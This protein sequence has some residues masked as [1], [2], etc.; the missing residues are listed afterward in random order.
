MLRFV[1]LLIGALF[2]LLVAALVSITPTDRVDAGQELVRTCDGDGDLAFSE[3]SN[4]DNHPELWEN[5]ANVK[6]TFGPVMVGGT[7]TLKI[8][9][10]TPDG[11]VSIQ[12]V[13]APGGQFSGSAP[14]T[15]AGISTRVDFLGRMVYDEKNPQ[16]PRKEKADWYVG[17]DGALPDSNSDGIHQPIVF[18]EL[19]FFDYEPEDEDSDGVSS[20]TD[21][22]STANMEGT[23]IQQPGPLQYN[24]TKKDETL[25]DVL[26]ANPGE[27]AIDSQRVAEGDVHFYQGHSI[28][29]TF[30]LELGAG[31]MFTFHLPA[32]LG[33]NDVAVPIR[34]DINWFIELNDAATQ[35]KSMSMIVDIAGPSFDFLNGDAETGVWRWETVQ[36]P[37]TG[38]LDL[39][40]G[41][42][43]IALQG[44]FIAENLKV[45][46]AGEE[47]IPL[48]LS[49][50]MTGTIAPFTTAAT[51]VDNCPD[52]ANADQL[53]TDADGIGDVCDFDFSDFDCDGDTDTTDALKQVSARAGLTVV[54]ELGC[55]LPGASAQFAGFSVTWGN[56][57]CDEEWNSM[58]GVNT[59][60]LIVGL[61][62]QQEANCPPLP[63]LG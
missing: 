25:V 26:I 13:Q 40:T 38:Q 36:D 61:E 21:S 17:A 62:V 8:E 53:D 4:L 31:S 11:P 20:T 50:E 32:E 24:V 30:V 10:T 9:F 45:T 18:N 42:F 49:G 33:G 22:P 39:N 57:D 16:K 48:T 41:A 19:C 58:D 35:I 5:I 51:L 60:A 46:T 28:D 54:Q 59:L 43:T 29:S 12:T 52:T 47:K 34:G 2:S 14:V 3:T 63:D 23:Y 1:Y 44:S 56:I 7:R 15:F 6:K 37:V 27:F 55:P